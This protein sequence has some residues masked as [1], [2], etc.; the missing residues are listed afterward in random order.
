[1]VQPSV[2]AGFE[3]LGNEAAPNTTT[4]ITAASRPIQNFVV[5]RERGAT[6]PSS[7]PP[8]LA[9]WCLAGAQS[10]ETLTTMSSPTRVLS[11]GSIL[12]RV[13]LTQMFMPLN[14]HQIANL[15]SGKW[16]QLRVVRVE[17]EAFTWWF[18]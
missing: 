18:C 3:I 9:Q 2:P 12:P 5:T 10:G 11:P 8:P 4:K 17:F 7:P 14:D 16:L 15:V 6:P 13:P 1:M